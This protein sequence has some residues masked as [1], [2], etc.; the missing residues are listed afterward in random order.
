MTFQVAFRL[1]APFFLLAA[2]ASA[3]PLSRS[4]STSKQ[5]VI[6][7][8]D[9]H[10][11]ASA[12]QAAEKT[13][14][15][16]LAF[17]HM[18]DRWS[19]PILL[20]LA[21]P[22]A[23]LPEVPAVALNF[24]QTGAGLKIQLDLLIDRA[25]DPT[26][27]RREVLRALLLEMSY[28]TLPSL[29]AGEVFNAPP[30]WL[31]DGLLT[32]DS[33][34]TA[35]LHALDSADP[36][37]LRTFLALRPALLDSQ[38]RALY[39]ACSGALVRL[40]VA[41]ADGRERLARYI[42]DWPHSSTETMKDLRT[43][44]PMIGRDEEEVEKNWHAA[45][46]HLTTNGQFALL[47]FEATSQQLDE[48]LGEN[49]AHDAAKKNALALEQV[50]GAAHVTIDKE[51]ARVLS[52]HLTLLGA[53]AHP[54]LRSIVA[55]YRG[56]AEAVSRGRAKSLQKRLGATRALRQ[57]V[58]DRMGQVDDYMNWF[59]ATQSQTSSGTFREYIRAVEM[60]ES[61]SQRHDPI[62]VYLDAMEAQLQ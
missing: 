30:D 21:Q 51:A 6:F 43:H 31:V 44:F 45:V 20:N 17:L 61:A 57:R 62:S 58:T 42:A 54:L 27:L 9:T 16:L 52:Q 37:P 50:I 49:I 13:K 36:P 32:F 60:K 46:V 25:F 10:L 4:V 7:G 34:S 5:F 8:E 19:V 11:R 55:D 38:S 29:P 47:G 1:N 56:F 33:Q 28:R 48:C 41:P 40:L 39:R 53:Q 3:A 2:Y 59:E 23:N 24:S 35:L 14:S 26:V 12:A 22:K 18:R 15:D